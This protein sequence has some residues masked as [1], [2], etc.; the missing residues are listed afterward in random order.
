MTSPD[1]QVVALVD[2]F[3][4]YHGIQSLDESRLKWCD[5]AKLLPQLLRPDERLAEIRYYTSDPAHRADKRERHAVYVAAVQARPG[6][7]VVV[8]NG[9]FQKT[10]NMIRAKVGEGVVLRVTDENAREEKETDVRIAVDMMDLAQRKA[11]DALALVCSDSD[12]MPAIERVL[13]RFANIRRFIL[14]HPPNRK[15][16]EMQKLAIKHP[17]R[18]RVSQIKRAH[19]EK[20]RM[21]DSFEA[22]GQTH[23]APKSY[24]IRPAKAL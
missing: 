13:E 7:P 19:L 10:V 8:F 2:G 11:C 3:N 4:L 17:G 12:Q 20:S 5:I 9:R 1:L 24:R 15:S 14:L 18:V 22:D 23:Q 6:P 21:P 16:E